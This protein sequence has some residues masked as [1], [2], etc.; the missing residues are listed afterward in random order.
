MKNLIR[1]IA[2]VVLAGMLLCSASMAAGGDTP[3]I[4]LYT[5]Y[6][7]VFPDGVT[8]EAGCVDE[9]GNLWTIEET[10]QDADWSAPM[11]KYLAS[12]LAD[13]KM[14]N[15]GQMGWDE[16]FEL[17]S[18][19]VSVEDQGNETEAVSEGGGGECSYALIY[20]EDEPVQR[21]LLGVSGDSRFEN[22]DPNAQA[23]YLQLRNLFPGVTNYFGSDAG[24]AGFQPVSLVEF[25]GWQDIDFTHVVITGWDMDCEAGPIPFEMSAENREELVRFIRNSKVTGKANATITTGGTTEYVISDENGEFLAS[26]ELYQGLL[27]RND[28]MY[29]LKQER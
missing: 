19:I 22:T 23:L 3:R 6:Q 28:G 21:I 13:G 11:D 29:F 7:N 14:T 24:P 18:L 26:L 15:A 27:V 2:A 12:L 5:C 17:N 16:L 25:C 8:L 20:A 4:I 9:E 1:T 10:I